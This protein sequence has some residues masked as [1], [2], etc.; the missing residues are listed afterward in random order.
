MNVLIGFETSGRTREAFRARG[1]NVL[2][3]DL[4]PAEDGSPHHYVGDFFDVAGLGWDLMVV[5][6]PCTYLTGSGLHWNKRRPERA[7]KTEEA[8]EFVKRVW[9]V[10]IHR[11]ALENPLGCLSTRWRPYQQRIQPYQFGEDASKGTCLWLENLPPLEIEPALRVPGRWVC[12]GKVLDIEKVG[13]YG[14][15]HC[16]GEKRPLERWAN[17]TDSGQNRLGPSEDRW[18]ERSRTYPGIALAFAKNWG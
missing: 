13:R 9:S 5:H 3:V 2:S 7:V 11:K 18:K 8:I 12:C 6:P 1:H 4:L 16:L 14:C 10:P 17:Q 15:P